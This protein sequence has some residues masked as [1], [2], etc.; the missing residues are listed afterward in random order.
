MSGEEGEVE[1]EEDKAVFAAVVGEGDL[2]GAL[3][4][5]S[6]GVLGGV[7]I[8]VVCVRTYTSAIPP[9]LLPD[10]SDSVLVLPWSFHLSARH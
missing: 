7:G 6:R 8:G 3:I 2:G 5:V 4:C 1:D 10:L 9:L